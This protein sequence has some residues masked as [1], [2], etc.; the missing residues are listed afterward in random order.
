PARSMARGR[1]IDADLAAAAGEHARLDGDL[2]ELH[3]GHG[4]GAIAVHLEL[5]VRPRSCA[6]AGPCRDR[7]FCIR[8]RLDVG[9]WHRLPDLEGDGAGTR[10][11]EVEAP[12][13]GR[14]ERQLHRAPAVTLERDGERFRDGERRFLPPERLRPEGDANLAPGAGL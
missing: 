12:A 4:G 7:P 3:E 6:V 11:A 5:A 2:G 1:R 13:A 8:G 9:G 14:L 10:K